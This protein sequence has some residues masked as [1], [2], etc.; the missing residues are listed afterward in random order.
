MT[1]LLVPAETSAHTFP[2]SANDDASNVEVLV[3]GE[4]G[5]LV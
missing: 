2:E 4:V 3:M 1:R 5:R